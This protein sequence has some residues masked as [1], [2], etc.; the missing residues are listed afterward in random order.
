M[1]R[2]S[3]NSRISAVIRSPL[4]PEHGTG[5]VA[6]VP[7]HLPEDSPQDLHITRLEVRAPED[8]AQ[9]D[10]DGRGLVAGQETDRGERL[11]EVLVE[12]LELGGSGQAQARGSGGL[13][14]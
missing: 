14:L 13:R 7:V 8:A 12:P 9:G 1:A 3:T 6:A 10:Q 11:L 2:I 4:T 5:G